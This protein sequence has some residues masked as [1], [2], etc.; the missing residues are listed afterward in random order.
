MP[1]I[2][3]LVLPVAGE[4]RRMRPLTFK[5]PKALIGLCGKPLLDYLLEEAARSGI[6]DVIFIINP[7]DKSHFRKYIEI[8]RKLFP[9]L[10]FFVRFQKKPA[11]NGHAILQ[12]ADVIG[13]SPFA[14]RFC[15]DL[16]EG[17]TPALASL[18]RFYEM[19]RTPV[20]LLERVPWRR[21][22][23]YGVVKIKKLKKRTGSPAGNLYRI[24][25][26]VEKPKRERAPSNLTI[27]GGYVLTPEILRNL[28]KIAD[29]LPNAGFDALPLA[30]AIQVEFI[31][32]GKVYGWEFPGRRFDCGN[33]EGF[34]TAERL[35]GK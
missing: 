9:R 22:S 2:T 24:M 34:R 28:G 18:I 26:I 11:G 27:V 8:R 14:V 16:I 23:R 32:G 30:V 17:N 35:L 20:L 7:H 25:E 13:S 21:V 1:T 5:T 31:V 6:G 33:F 10:R 29:S 15:D 12:A 19:Y 4:G 3:K